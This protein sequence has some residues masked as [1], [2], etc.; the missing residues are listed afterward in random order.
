MD[1]ITRDIRMAGYRSCLSGSIPT[2]I[3]GTNDTGLNGSDT[4]SIQMSDSACPVVLTTTSYSINNGISGQPAVFKNDGVNNLELIEGIEDM[5]ILYGEDTNA[6]NTPDYYVSA[7]NISDMN[8]V[9]SIRVVLTVRS[10]DA[11][12]ML[13]GDGRLRRNFISTIAVRNRLP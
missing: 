4:I 13:T 5:Q 3:N 2:P 1:F 6:D 7:G 8:K 9:V 12:L 11:K 10:L